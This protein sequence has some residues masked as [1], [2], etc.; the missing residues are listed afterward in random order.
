MN[1]IWW[2]LFQFKDKKKLLEDIG[3][4][5]VDTVLWALN[6]LP[7]ILFLRIII[8]ISISLFFL[9]NLS[10]ISHYVLQIHS[11]CFTNW[12]Y[13]P[14]SIYVHIFLI[15]SWLICIMLLRGMFSRLIH[16]HWTANCCAFSRRNVLL[17]AWLSLAANS[18]LCRVNI[19]WIFICTFRHVLWYSSCSFHV[20]TVIWVRV[21]ECNFWY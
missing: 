5:Q 15:I 9:P 3:K 12:Y 2:D 21:Y 17:L 8:I 1:V 10:H 13:M 19:L 11:L 6:L 14:I 7:S 16:W 4:W 20:W 18:S